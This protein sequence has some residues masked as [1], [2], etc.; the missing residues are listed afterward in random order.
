M[1][2]GAYGMWGLFPAFFPLLK[3]AGAVEILAHRMVWTLVFMLGLLA[4]TGRLARLRGIP[5]RTWLM[6][7]A[8]S[9][10]I[11]VNWGTYIYAVNSD[12]VVEAALGYFINPL[13]SVLL[14]VVVLRERLRR[15]QLV[16][17]LVAL[18]AVVVLTVAY[19]R[20]PFIALTLA[21]SFGLYGLVKKTIRLDP[22]TSLTAEGIVVA[23]LAVGYLVWLQVSGESTFTTHGA[24]HALLLVTAG[25]VTA[26][27]LLLFG[28]AAQRV[29]LVTIGMLQYLTPVLQLCWGL[30]VV[31]ETMPASRWAGFVIIWV[32]LAIF[33]ADAVVTA[34]RSAR[35]R[36]A[37]ALAT[38]S[39]VP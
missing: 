19:G 4:L 3:P 26:L 12:H 30:L 18:S 17:L 27:P 22:R 13:L 24:G 6:A 11:A 39:I 29:P 25:V 36:S 15:W 35:S 32:A 9:V 28:G 21:C 7:A 38:S 20:P 16:A 5:A 8:A 33:T 34:R 37:P 31:H 14:G 1:G 2:F 10:L 23:P